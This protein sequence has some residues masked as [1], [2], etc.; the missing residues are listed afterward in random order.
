[1]FNKFVEF[2]KS[3]PVAQFVLVFIAGV[4]IGALF[5]PTKRIEDRVHQ[6]DQLIIDKLTTEKEE[7]RTT[8]TQQITSITQ[9]KNEM[10]LSMTQQLME[11][12]LEVKELQ[13][14][15]KEVWYK[16]VK[17][18]GT[19]EERRYSESEVNESSQVISS[20]QQEYEKKITELNTQWQKTVD[21]KLQEQQVQFDKINKENERKIS[22]LES[23][24]TVTINEKKYG[25][26]VG[27]LTSA[28]YYGHVNVDLFGPI[29]IG[30]H[31]NTN[32]TNSTSVGAGL[33][34]RF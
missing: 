25:L 19:I 16:I 1:M 17:P 32:L 22:E 11:L 26:E 18:D 30:A 12:R 29:F 7:I 6:Q 27:Y 4:A 28:Q 14:K 15:K 23:S 3:H 9:Q 20:V 5:Y 13:S 33:G 8:L 21:S 24:H 10:Q 34:I 2:V 31:V